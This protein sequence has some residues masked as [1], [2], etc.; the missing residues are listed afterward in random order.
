MWAVDCQP[1]L[2]VVL[3]IADAYQYLAI[4]LRP[5][6][7]TPRLR[8]NGTTTALF[9]KSAAGPRSPASADGDKL[10]LEKSVIRMFLV[11]LLASNDPQNIPSQQW[12]KRTASVWRI[13]YSSNTEYCN[14][15]HCRRNIKLYSKLNSL[16]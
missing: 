16:Y 10:L 3:S 9:G 11:S 13:Y 5:A 14:E 12:D 6:A 2:F 7:G 4:H 15:E 8:D 1:K